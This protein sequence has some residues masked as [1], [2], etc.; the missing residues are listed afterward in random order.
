[1]LD[2]GVYTPQ[3]VKASHDLN[4]QPRKQRPCWTFEGLS[5]YMVGVTGHNSQVTPH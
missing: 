3:N 5:M 2:R 4:I 1:L